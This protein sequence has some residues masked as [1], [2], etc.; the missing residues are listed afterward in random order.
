[1]PDRVVEDVWIPEWSAYVRVS[2]WDG[3]TRWR[4]VQ[5]WPRGGNGH[6][7]TNLLALVAAVSLVD[8]AGTRLFTDAD[9][10][11]L[12]QKN[13]RALDRVFAVALRLNG[14]DTTAVD[15]LGKDSAPAVNGGSTST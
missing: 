5:A 6:P 15:T 8:A 9:V 3:T 12:A 11:A 10:P 14:L 2:G 1:V 4:I 7:D 13:A